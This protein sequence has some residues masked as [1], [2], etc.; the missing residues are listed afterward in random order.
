M[1]VRPDIT[2]PVVPRVMATAAEMQVACNAIAMHRTAARVQWAVTFRQVH[3]T[4]D[5]AATLVPV[6]ALFALW[7]LTSK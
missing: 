4:Q 7:A 2:R 5:M 3:A 6:V 1:Y